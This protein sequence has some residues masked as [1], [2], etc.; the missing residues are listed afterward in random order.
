MASVQDLLKNVPYALIPEEGREAN[1]LANGPFKIGATSHVYFSED[2]RYVLK[3]VFDRHASLFA[4]YNCAAR[5]Y[6]VVQHHLSGC[7]WVPHMLYGDADILVSHYCGQPVTSDTIPVNWQQQA[8]QILLDMESRGVKHNDIKTAEV[9]IKDD[10]MYLCD[11]GWAS[12][13]DD[14]SV[15][16]EDICADEKPHGITEDKDAL[17]KLLAVIAGGR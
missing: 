13:N 17:M 2:Q 14:F 12:V 3:H 7:S 5:E 8:Q 15:G 6:V 9:L 11:F 4:K 1:M 16:R 10:K